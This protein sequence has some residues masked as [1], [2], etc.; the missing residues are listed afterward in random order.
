M[1][2][3]RGWFFFLPWAARCGSGGLVENA[4][5]PHTAVDNADPL[6]SLTGC[7]VVDVTIPQRNAQDWVEWR[8]AGSDSRTGAVVALRE[9]GKEDPPHDP[10]DAPPFLTHG[11]DDFSRHG[12]CKTPTLLSRP[13][14]Q[15]LRIH[16]GDP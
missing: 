8:G 2:P 11:S 12:L 5:A 9:K 4:L 14:N 15:L 7:L 13:E 10:R 1:R 6:Q 3:A 16:C